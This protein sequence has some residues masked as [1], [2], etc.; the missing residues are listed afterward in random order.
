MSATA[1][2]L[3]RSLASRGVR[4]SRRDD[5]LR[6]EA[7]QGTVTPE[8]RR[9]LTERKRDLLAAL[10]QR[11]RLAT[12]ACEEGL[13][14]NL[15]INLTADELAFCES[16]DDAA[17]RSYLSVIR[18]AGVRA[19]GCVPPDETAVAVCVR[20]GP[21]WV[22]PLVVVVAPHVGGFARVIGCPWCTNRAN[23]IAIPRPPVTCG[24]CEHFERDGVNPPAGIGHCRLGIASGPLPYPFAQRTCA[25]W[26]PS[27]SEET[28]A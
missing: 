11:L 8:L 17:A 23:G 24:A 1:E 7:P 25:S 6:V 5:R 14:E 22:H 12:I 20:C 13:D 9:V 19:G 3:I 28:G 21:V 27:A 2:T 10:D 16:L 4:L 18:D 15:V 26:T